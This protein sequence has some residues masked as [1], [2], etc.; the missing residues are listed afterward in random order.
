MPDSLIIQYTHVCYN[1]SR[2]LLLF[3]IVSSG[4]TLKKK[5]T[6]S[7]ITLRHATHIGPVIL[8]LLKVS[9]FLRA[10]IVVFGLISVLRALQHIL[11]HFG[12][13]QLT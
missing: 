1:V 9:E 7:E 11:G 8:S 5:Q 12:R 2:L 6:I 10:H 13:G 3:S 4:F